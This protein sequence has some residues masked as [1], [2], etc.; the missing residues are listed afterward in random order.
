MSRVHPKKGV[1]ELV[2]AWSKVS[3]LTHV[4]RIVGPDE[5]GHSHEVSELIRELGVSESVE[6]VGPR[7]DRERVSEYLN[8]DVF[9]LPTYSENF[10]LVVAEALSYGIPVITTKG[11]PWEAL[12]QHKCGWWVDVGEQS[13]VDV[14]PLALSLSDDERVEMGRRAKNLASSFNWN[15]IADQTLGFYNS[16][17]QHGHE[18]TK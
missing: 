11:A 4:L 9:V 8:A 16:V 6:L 10:G 17:L 2:R 5:G 3:S 7:Y 18:K 1:V 13:L 15:F 14:L 12:A